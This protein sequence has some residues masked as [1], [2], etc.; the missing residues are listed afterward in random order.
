MRKAF[1]R[2]DKKRPPHPVHLSFSLEQF[3]QNSQNILEKQI[4][5]ESPLGQGLL[6]MGHKQSPSHLK[7]IQG[8]FL[9]LL[10]THGDKCRVMQMY[11]FYT[12]G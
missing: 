6:Q 5:G 11:K 3:H 7:V 2:N 4:V 12:R 8:S 9:L 1:A 10:F